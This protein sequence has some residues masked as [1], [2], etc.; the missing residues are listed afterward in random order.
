MEE[1]VSQVGAMVRKW[2]SAEGNPT[3]LHPFEARDGPAQPSGFAALSVGPRTS[4][5]SPRDAGACRF[6]RSLGGGIDVERI[7]P[8]VSYVHPLRTPSAAYLGLFFGALAVKPRYRR[9]PRLWRFFVQKGL[10][11]FA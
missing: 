1:I 5:R 2:R 8:G 7:A 3:V 10:S 4:L 11:P 9:N 6:S